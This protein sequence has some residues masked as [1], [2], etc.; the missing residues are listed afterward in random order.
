VTNI[1]ATGVYTHT[2]LCCCDGLPVLR[3]CTTHHHRQASAHLICRDAL[4]PAQCIWPHSGNQPVQ[5]CSYA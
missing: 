5:A 4:Q 3:T 1:H 2:H